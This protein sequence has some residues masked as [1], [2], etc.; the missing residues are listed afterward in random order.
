MLSLLKMPVDL[1]F[2]CTQILPATLVGRHW[3]LC[4]T[5]EETEAQ[6]AEETCPRLLSE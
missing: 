1:S 2:T 5:D 4:F 6:Q 3:H